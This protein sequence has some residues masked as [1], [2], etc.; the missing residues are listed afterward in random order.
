MTKLIPFFAL[1]A[2]PLVLWAQQDPTKADPSENDF[3]GAD[4]PTVADTKPSTADPTQQFNEQVG[5][6]KWGANAQSDATWS[7]GWVGGWPGSSSATWND[8][9]SYD[10]LATAF[11]DSRPKKD[12]RFRFSLQAAA[13]FQNNAAVLNQN[14]QATTSTVQVPNIKI[15]EMFT[16]VTI[17][18]ALYLRFGKQSASWGV[19][20]FYS[21]A[22]IIS[23]S[24]IN[25]TNPTLQREGP[26]ALKA[27]VPF[28]NQKANLT[29]FV[30][31]QNSTFNTTTTGVSNLGYA[32]QGDVLIGQAQATLGGFYQ[33]DS[34]PKL[35]ATV[36]TG[37]GFLNLPV[38]GDVNVFTEAILS[39][40]SDVL[41][42]SG[43]QSGPLGTTYQALAP[44]AKTLYYTG[45]A[46]ASYNNSDYNF[47]LRVEYLYNPFGSS[48]KNAAATGYNTYLATQAGMY[49]GRNSA[50]RAY[51][52]NDILT[53]GIHNLTGLLD[54]TKLGGS[55]LEFSTLVQHN[56]SDT[57]GWA[58]PY[59]TLYPWDQLGFRWGFRTVYGDAGTQFPL[60][61]Q[62]F[63]STGVPSGATQRV[64]LMLEVFFGTGQY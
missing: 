27:S 12:L 22:D 52:L 41:Q 23:L 43:S 62:T 45:T 36:N 51:N 30:L 63:S 59:F 39:D 38:D 60:Q 15:W 6:A 24:Q 28:P 35:V 1:V 44:W 46:G 21:A 7:P 11:M 48:D 18:D 55:K 13:P 29:A 26:I 58:Y 20:Y 50:S 57:S 40:G 10:L 64:N 9:L 42:G 3:F 25:V 19:A 8:A 17:A 53:P 34:A 56:L 14:G 5:G 49:S 32:L 2:F 16:D 31:T 47:S 61:Y 33:K 54:F 37:L 4:A